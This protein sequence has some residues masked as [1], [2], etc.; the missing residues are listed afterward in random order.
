MALIIKATEQKKIN[1]AGTELELS[2]IYGRIEFVGR[3]DGK[4]IEIATATYTS[5]ATFEQ[6]KPVFTDIPSGNVNAQIEPTEEQTI[7]TAHKYGKMAYE[8]LGYEVIID[9]TVA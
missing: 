6:G 1:I 5:K 8:Q 2:E 7:N 9:M 3:A 4:T